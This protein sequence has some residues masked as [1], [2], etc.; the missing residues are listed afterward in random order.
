MHVRGQV[1]RAFS[2]ERIPAGGIGAALKLNIET[3]A[4]G[5]FINFKADELLQGPP[6]RPAR[7]P[8]HNLNRL[9]AATCNF[10]L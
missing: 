8:A 3:V 9:Q 1:N 4:G 5:N 7:G 6:G 2:P 10:N